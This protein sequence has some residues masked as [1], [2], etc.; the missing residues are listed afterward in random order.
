M[1]DNGCAGIYGLAFLGAAIYFVQH[2]TSFWMGV[3]GVI[4]AVFW[5]AVVMYRVLELLKLWGAATA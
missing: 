1:K 2:A 5:P 4:K 3:L